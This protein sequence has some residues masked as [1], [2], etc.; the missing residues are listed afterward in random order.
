LVN[1]L[2]WNERASL[3]EPPIL[4]NSNDPVQDNPF[5]PSYVGTFPAGASRVYLDGAYW[6]ALAILLTISGT[7]ILFG[8]PLGFVAMLACGAAGIRVPLVQRRYSRMVANE[9]QVRSI[10]PSPLALLFSS[11]ALNIVFMVVS[12][13]AFMTVCIPVTLAGIPNSGV[14]FQGNTVLMISGAVGLICFGLLFFLSL[15]FRF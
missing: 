6:I 15:R 3:S 14:W 7:M 9:L 1:L 4:P 11:L 10:L 5:A 12:F 13:I 8:L 2:S